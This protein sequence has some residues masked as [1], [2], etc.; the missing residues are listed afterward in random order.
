M[1]TTLERNNLTLNALTGSVFFN[2]NIGG[3]QD[4]GSLTVTEADGVI[5]F[6]DQDAKSYTTRFYRVVSH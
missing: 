3:T 1:A 6:A 5:Q 2:A 4:L